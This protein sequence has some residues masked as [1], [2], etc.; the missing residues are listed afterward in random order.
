MSNKGLT[1]F[2]VLVLTSASSFANAQSYTT[3]DTIYTP[4]GY[5]DGKMTGTVYLPK[6]PNGVGIVAVH[7]ILVT[8]SSMTI[9]CDTL[10][11]HG[12]TVMTIDYPDPVGQ[13]AK[14]PLPIRAFKTAVQFMRKNKS[15]LRLTSDHVLA[16]GRSMGAA[17]IAQA[18]VDEED[19][20]ALGLDNSIEDH[21]NLA[22]LFYGLYDYTHFTATNLPLNIATFSTQYFA[23]S[24]ATELKETPVR[25]TNRV[26]TSLL[27][28]HGTGDATLQFEQS[29]E[30]HDSLVKNA[31]PNHLIFFAGEPHLFETSVDN[32]SFTTIGLKAKDSV[33]AFL[34][35]SKE[36]VDQPTAT[37]A[38]SI[39]LQQSYPNPIGLAS[40]SSSAHTTIRFQLANSGFCTL[41]LY[42]TLGEQIQIVRSGYFVSG[43]HSATLDCSGLQSGVYYYKIEQGASSTMRKLVVMN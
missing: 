13:A 33:L 19:F 10:A 39:T 12:F 4:T 9:W 24:N 8:R 25:Q 20:A 34:S 14:F 30:L 37:Q 32:S 22:I 36:S 1:L 18:I 3:F 11:A 17:V 27:L 2:F 42:N 38:A 35:A 23:G 21:V 28:L 5:S 41:A 40:A 29:Q 6:A 43:E 16:I 7:E 15:L 31:K 26:S